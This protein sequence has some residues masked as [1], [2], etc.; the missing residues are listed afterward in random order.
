MNQLQ[1]ESDSLNLFG[2]V[3]MNRKQIA[4][5]LKSKRFELK[6]VREAM[7]LVEDLDWRISWALDFSQSNR[8]NDILDPIQGP[9]SDAT[10]ELQELESML[11]EQLNEYRHR[12][13][14]MKSEIAYEVL[15]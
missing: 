6:Q 1:K 11:E 14:E 5:T 2:V 4:T 12:V 7:K 13:D 3:N 10:D 8:I 15:S 9:L